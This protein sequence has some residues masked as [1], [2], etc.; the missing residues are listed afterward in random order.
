MMRS[1][2][3]VLMRSSNCRGRLLSRR[4]PYGKLSSFAPACGSD[5]F[6]NQN[7]NSSGTS[8]TPPPLPPATASLGIPTCH[9]RKRMPYCMTD[10]A[11]MAETIQEI[12]EAKPGELFTYQD[13][14]DTRDDAWDVCDVPV[15]KIEAALRGLSYAVPG[16]MWNRY[17]PNGSDEMPPGGAEYVI[18]VQKRLLDRLY[19]EGY[20]YMSI[21][22][23]RMTE[24]NNVGIDNFSLAGWNEEQ[25]TSDRKVRKTLDPDT[26]GISDLLSGEDFDL[27][28]LQDLAVQDESYDQEQERLEQEKQTTQRAMEVKS[29]DGT[30]E[31]KGYM[32]DF[33]LPGPTT[34]MFD[35]ALDVYACTAALEPEACLD[36]AHQLHDSAMI[37]HTIDGGDGK[38]TNPFT[39]PTQ[40]TFNAL[41]RLAANLPYNPRTSSEEVRDYAVG[42]AFET[43]QAMHECGVVHRNS[44]TYT[45]AL[46]TVAKYMPPSRIRGNIAFGVFSQARYKCLI[47]DSVLTAYQMANQPSNA[48]EHDK[49]VAETI[50]TREFPV[51]WRRDSRKKQFNQRDDVY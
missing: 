5:G 47:N 18:S 9:S 29:D 50:V 3:H 23:L 15:Q 20:A 6:G 30:P 1:S 31:K 25:Q 22:A 49:F 7:N 45:Y 28:S 21:R 36:N 2:A 35:T 14:R 16:S 37:R 43:F 39:Y 51:K 42:T 17:V 34:A 24:L 38:N 12:E 40:L 27:S 11:E 26:V 46:L 48:P 41:I 32:H 19:E 13:G 8:S 4:V 33:A 44:A 10:F